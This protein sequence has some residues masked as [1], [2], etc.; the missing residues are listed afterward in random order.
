MCDVIMWMWWCDD[1]PCRKQ[2]SVAQLQNLPVDGGDAAAGELW[3][4]TGRAGGGG[5]ETE[6]GRL[7]LARLEEKRNQEDEHCPAS[8]LGWPVLGLYRNS[9]GAGYIW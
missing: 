9:T 3:A 1:V 2:D 8:E 6:E 5:G 4:A 7:R